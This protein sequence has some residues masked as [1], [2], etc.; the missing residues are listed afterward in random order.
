[1]RTIFFGSSSFSVPALKS[2]AEHTIC[3]VT[4]KA[5]PKGRGYALDDN[6]VKMAAQ[7]LN[8]PLI[9]IDSFKD[10]VVRTLPDHK[11]D[12]FAVVSFGLI[13]PKWVLD[14]P[15][16]GP[17]NVHPSL[18]P[19]YRGP[20]PMQWAILSGD[21]TTGITLIRMNEKMDAGD[22]IYQEQVGI[23]QG[24]NFIELSERLAKR[25]S[26]ILP[27]VLREI[28]ARGTIEGTEQRHDAATYTPII[29]KQ[30]GMIDWSKSAQEID[31]Q[32]RALVSWPTA[33][34]YLDGRMMKVFEASVEQDVQAKEKQGRIGAIVRDGLL[35]DCGRGVLR[36]KEIQMENKRR[37]RAYDFA[38]GYRDLVGKVLGG[39]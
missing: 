8:L 36:L 1:M 22:V 16:V 27:E 9:E 35:A 13:V 18:L 26:E 6:E 30:M 15:S 29:T 19:L 39:P 23:G 17:I 11:P 20:S 21:E 14:I 4:K 5:K 28:H 24:E 25:V 34:T 38:Q 32:V 12:F 33:Y 3:V 7:E 31:R 2:I 10:E 37:M